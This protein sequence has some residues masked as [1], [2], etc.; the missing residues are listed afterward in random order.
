MLG[1]RGKERGHRSLVTHRLPWLAIL[2]TVTFHTILAL[3]G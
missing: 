2:S 1:L 3:S